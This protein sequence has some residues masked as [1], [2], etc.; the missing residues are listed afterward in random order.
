MRRAGD[1]SLRLTN[2]PEEVWR[3]RNR[4]ARTRDQR[5]PRWP[6]ERTNAWRTR[7]RR[8]ANA[9]DRN[10]HASYRAFVHPG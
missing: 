7:K 6:V 5:R 8:I 4:V 3:G 2:A 1:R 9:V 10:N